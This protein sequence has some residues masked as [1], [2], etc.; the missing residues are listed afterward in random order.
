M[1]ETTKDPLPRALRRQV[2][3]FAKEYIPHL[4]IDAMTREGLLDPVRAP[5][6]VASARSLLE[7]AA[8]LVSG[9]EKGPFTRYVV[10]GCN[11]S[12]ADLGEE[13]IVERT[14][15]SEAETNA[16]EEALDVADGWAETSVY[17]NRSDA[18]DHVRDTGGE[19]KDEDAI[20]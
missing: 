5:D 8:K 2:I 3:R 9:M 17:D 16:F 10:T 1:S 12:V 20:E 14:F 18:V 11:S 4:V 19:V 15:E 6:R 13:A 7:E